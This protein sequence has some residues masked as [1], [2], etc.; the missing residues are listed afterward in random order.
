MLNNAFASLKY[1]QKCNHDV[2]I[3]SF[4]VQK[5]KQ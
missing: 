5:T 3:P 2:Q 4:E 1:S